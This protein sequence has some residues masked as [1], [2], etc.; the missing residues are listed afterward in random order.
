MNV[1]C[2]LLDSLNRHFLPAYGND[3]VQT[4]NLDRLAQRSAVFTNNYIGSMP[5]MPT[6]RDLWTG[7]LEFPWRPWGSLEPYDNPLPRVLSDNGV[8]TMLVSDHYHLWEDGGENYHT[9]FEGWEFIRG[10]ENDPWATEPAPRPERVKDGLTPRYQR[11]MARFQREEDWLSPR[12]LK[13][14]ADWLECNHHAHDRFFLMVDEFDPHE[15]FHVPPP[16]DTLYDPDWNGP[17]FV[18]PHYGRNEYTEAE[19]RH[20]RAQY[21]GKVTLADRWLGRLLDRMDDFGLWDNTMLIL[22]TDHGHFL[23]DH[24]W[25]GKPV[26][27]QYEAIAHRPLMIH[28][29]GDLKA[30]ER[31]GGLNTTVDLYPTILE[32]FDLAPPGP[33]HGRSILPLMDG[34]ADTIRDHA[35]YGFFGSYTQVTDGRRTY[36]RGARDPENGPLHIYTNRWSTA[37][38]WRIPQPDA[39]MEIGDYLP[40]ACGMPVGRMPV[41]PD[42]MRRLSCPPEG[43]VGGSWLFDIEQDPGETTNLAGGELEAQYAA[44]MRRGLEDIGAPVEQYERMGL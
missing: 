20:A 22:M 6:R 35:L 32:G 30:G 34:R 5:C 18:W 14:A 15:P 16:Y 3:W 31:V 36:L 4:P 19:A 40:H 38:W 39:R 12:T 10:H 1:I 37:P 26:C 13:T 33:C 25:W 7:C 42:I 9:S 41:D 11:N 2:V 21:A 44:L 27:P 43:V 8:M 29:P 17:F 28:L 23:G 24:G